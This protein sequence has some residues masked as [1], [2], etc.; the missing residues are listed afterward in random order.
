MTDPAAQ[1]TGAAQAKVAL[2]KVAGLRKAA[3]TLVTGAALVKAVAPVKVAGLR[4]I[5][6]TLA[7]GAVPT[8]VD[9]VKGAARAKAV[10]PP[11]GP[12]VH[13][14]EVDHLDGQVR[15][16]A[17]KAIN[18]QSSSLRTVRFVDVGFMS[19]YHCSLR[20]CLALR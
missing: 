18:V 7:T 14:T 3:A 9:Q 5:V 17:D 16:G 15:V 12:K 6:A 13:Q 10:V 2:V 11:K 19:Y 8:Q 4:K 1:V 20:N